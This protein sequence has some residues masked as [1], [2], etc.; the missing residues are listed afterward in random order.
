[1]HQEK[2]DGDTVTH[3]STTEARSGSR[4]KVTRN[5]LIISLVLIT[6]AFIAALGFGYFQTAKTGA[7]NITADNTARNETP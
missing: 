6:A 4:T 3:L 2:E 7:D 1:M 5:I